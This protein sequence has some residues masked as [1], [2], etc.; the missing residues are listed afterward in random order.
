MIRLLER[1]GDVVDRITLMPAADL[2]GPPSARSA[3]FPTEWDPLFEALR[4]APRTRR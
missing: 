4:S 3:L 2:P 1:F